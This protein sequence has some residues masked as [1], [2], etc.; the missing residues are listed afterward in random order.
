LSGFIDADGSFDIRV[1]QTDGGAS[2]NRV[3]A[4]L[5]L[6]QRM[7]DPDT[8]LSY[9]NIMSLIAAGFAVTLNQSTHN[10]NV[11]Y[12]LISAT[13]N[14]ARNI[15]VNYFTMFPLF[16]SKRLNYLDWLTCHNLIVN[17]T[18]T[19]QEGRDLAL[20]LKSKMNSKRT[21]YN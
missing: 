5:R 19:T 9:Q 3:S 21:F 13:S 14:I 12:F 2:K 6:E 8:G 20:K 7:V 1:S 18:H 17:K 15:I 16:S 10:S 11:Q 4:R